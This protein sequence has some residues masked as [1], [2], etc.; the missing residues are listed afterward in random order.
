MTTMMDDPLMPVSGR[1]ALGRA[2]TNPPASAESPSTS[3]VRPFGLRFAKPGS[4]GDELLPAVTLCPERQ[5]AL[6]PDGTPLHHRIDDMTKPSTGPHPDGS[7]SGQEEWTP[8]YVG[9]E[10]SE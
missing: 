2:R 3:G 4:T 5:I 9:D 10:A 7:G 8:D 1:F 6:L